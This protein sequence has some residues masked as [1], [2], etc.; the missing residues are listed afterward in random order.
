MAKGN[1]QVKQTE[2][3]IKD[4]QGKVASAQ[5]AAKEAQRELSKYE[6]D[7]DRNI[8]KQLN[9][10]LSLN[11]AQASGDRKAARRAR[12]RVN[13]LEKEIE[14]IQGLIDLQ[15][16]VINKAQKKASIEQDQVKA[17]EERIQKEME[18]S[19]KQE[20]ALKKKGELFT[21]L[22]KTLRNI[23][24]IGGILSDIFTDAAKK[25][26]ETGSTARGFV[27][28]L[29]SIAKIAGPAAL[30]K[31]MLNV[32]TETKTISKNLGISF[33]SA[34]KIR[35]EFSE[36]S[37]SSNDVRINSAK[38]V[39]AQTELVK[40]FGLS[41]QASGEVSQ[42]FIRNS[43]YL[44]VSAE[45]AGKLEKIIA[46]TGGNSTEFSESLALAANQTGKL[47]G[48]NLPLAKV[49]EKINTL[50]GASLSYIMDSPAALAKAVA[51]S[52]KLG[53]EFG[54]IRSIADGL[55]NFEN[56]IT[57][58]LEAELYLGRDINL[59]KARRL[60]FMGDEV[61]LAEEIGKQ[62]GTVADFNAMLPIQQT[63]FA[64]SLGMSRDE[65]ANMVM[66][67]ELSARFGEQAKNYT[68]EQL[69]A[70]KALA[71]DKNISD[72]A[73]LRLIQEEVDATKNFTE[74]AEKIRTAFQDAIVGLTPFLE[75]T[76]KIVGSLAKSPMAKILS[77][78]A[79][80]VG[81]GLALVKAFRAVTGVQRVFVVN[82]GTGSDTGGSIFDKMNSTRKSMRSK[83][84]RA[85]SFAKGAL[86]KGSELD[87][88]YAQRVLN[89]VKGFFG[90]GGM[91]GKRAAIGAFKGAKNLKLVRGLAGGGVAALGGMAVSGLASKA[92][93]KGKEGLAKGLGAAGGA[94]S[95]AGTGAMIG[96][97][98]PVIGTGIGAAVGGLIGGVSGFLDKQEAAR[99]AKR[100]KIE[101]EISERDAVAD[102]LRQIKTLLAESESGVYID[103]DR[104]GMSL[105]KGASMPKASYQ[106]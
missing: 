92:A 55:S 37:E 42:N 17:L 28:V 68:V 24:G 90:K 34:R 85:K 22:A 33:D 53:I 25:I 79:M 75:G 7:L 31:G 3:E 98:I 18:S 91:Q 20:K 40:S 19:A 58:E 82:N 78:A 74:A 48:V 94:L 93:A 62:I 77:V 52:E 99:Q 46:T 76:A 66:Q 11:A 51:M 44:G 81:T 100:E 2:Q 43:E 70:A 10:V 102:E 59:N 35:E 71:G 101:K 69:Q 45:A 4:L 105:L 65:L 41:V 87:A 47:Y 80:G 6:R 16:K 32:S 63:A 26:E 61:G 15:D 60:A 57:A 1:E 89:P 67:Q 84:R 9:A 64:K 103:G 14:G 21:D 83:A 95:G 106:L 88:R 30:L 104:V 50:Q 36:I 5:A 39:K 12:G 56:S 23:P 73:A 54:K 96:S 27:S 72:K 13:D 29:S 86:G 49:I 8:Q 97:I 38:L